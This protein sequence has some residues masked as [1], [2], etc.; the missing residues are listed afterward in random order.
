ML[1]VYRFLTTFFFPFILI[2]IF[3][4]KLLGK[5]DSKRYREK[6]FSSSFLSNRNFKKKLIW[7]H[8]ASIGE[9]TSVIPV[10]KKLSEENLELDFLLT[11]VTLSSGNLIKKSFSKNNNIQHRYLPID[12]NHLVKSFLDGWKPDLIMFV[13]SEIWPNFLIEI[14]KRKIKS[15]L[16]NGRVTT[17]TYK[18]W[19]LFPKIAEKIFDTFDLCLASSENSFKN[20]QNL[21]VKNVKYF[22]NLKFITE[23]KDSKLDEY[24]KNIFRNNKVW[25]AASTHKGEEIFCL[26]THIAIKKVYNNILTIIIPR[27]INRAREIEKL[28]QSLNLETQIISDQDTIQENR[29]IIIINSFGNLSKYFNLCK[30]IFMGKSNLKKLELVGGQNP[31]EA[32]VLGC[33]IY[34]GP[35]VY[36]FNEIYNLL[37]SYNI[38]EMINDND[39][40]TRK[41]INDFTVEKIIKDSDIKAIKEYGNKIL[42]STLVEIKNL[43]KNENL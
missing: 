15:L 29:E 6:I 38:S 37:Q 35:Y 8:A 28:A 40:L 26:K 24:S 3:F 16:I 41:L 11:T 31:I 12:S 36:N 19:K 10:I 7:I 17:K 30:S 27:H 18:R 1:F 39:D 42:Y 21:K 20:L 5:E 34:H 32:A 22:G 25:C 33:K 2:L 23:E 13:D 9:I 43:M 14:E 4:R